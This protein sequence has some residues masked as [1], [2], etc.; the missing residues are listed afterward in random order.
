MRLVT[1]KGALRN[2]IENELREENGSTDSM[3]PRAPSPGRDGL[4][5]NRHVDSD[6]HT[7]LT[8]PAFA[9]MVSYAREKPSD[10]EGSQAP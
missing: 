1:Y 5:R 7:L 3:T 4:D 6:G 9:G 8:D 10:A 2:T